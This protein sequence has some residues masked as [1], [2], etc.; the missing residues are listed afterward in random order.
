MTSNAANPALGTLQKPLVVAGIDMTAAVCDCAASVTYRGV[1][2]I[3]VPDWVKC[4]ILGRKRQKCVEEKIAQAQKDRGPYEERIHAP[5]G[6]RYQS[7]K[8]P[9]GQKFCLPDFVVGTGDKPL[10]AS[11]IK[12]IYE[13]KTPCNKEGDPL[14]S[15]QDWDPYTLLGRTMKKCYQKAHLEGEKPRPEGIPVKAIGPTAESCT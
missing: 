6:A 15:I 1:E 2:R 8:L 10:S 7:T 9:P 5:A 11:Q 13:L 12:A 4:C 3:P 14:P